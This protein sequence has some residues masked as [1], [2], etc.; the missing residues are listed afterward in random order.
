MIEC[1]VCEA[2]DKPDPAPCSTCGKYQCRDY[3]P[4][5]GFCANGN[6]FCSKKCEEYADKEDEQ[7]IEDD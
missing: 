4:I 3:C 7:E 5:C 6:T 1:G 2:M